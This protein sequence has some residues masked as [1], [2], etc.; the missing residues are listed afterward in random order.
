MKIETMRIIDRLVGTPVCK[1]LG[2]L[3]PVLSQ[4]P[5]GDTVILCKFFGIGSICLSYPL[6]EELKRQNKEVTYLTFKSNEAMV[7]GLGVE[8][9][10][11]ID[12]SSPVRFLGDMV[13]VIRDLRRLGPAVFLNLEFFSRFAAIMSLLSGAPVR[14]GFHMLHLPVGNLYSHRANLNVYR[15]IFENYM[16]VGMAAG[17]VSSFQP[18][19]SYLETFPYHPKSEPLNGISG[20]Y[21]VLNAESSE[22]I[23]A[24]RAWPASAW[25]DLIKRLRN[26]CP[27]H[28]LVMV[29]TDAGAEIYNEIAAHLSEDT[30]IISLV[31]RTSFAE[32]SVVL[33][34][35]SL[36]I[37]VD[38]GP[39]HLS[40]FMKRNTVGLFGPETPVLYGYQL[41]WV[42]NI[43]KNLI[44]SPCL[45]LYDAKK[46]VLDCRD[47]QCMKQISP[48]DVMVEVNDLMSQGAEFQKHFAKR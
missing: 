34:N 29:G 6:I 1:L 2:V 30:N 22:T 46:S 38:S 15:S 47:N 8:Q 35:A 25:V 40:A 3:A 14:A 17:A 23:Q 44:C 48:G 42:R 26:A 13:R 24:L 28:S 37:S 43:H 10:Y 7:R 21:I 20:D 11:T 9:C 31:G 36:V 33:C 45:A 12:P 39:L 27:D 32:F 41:P 5:E 18:L 4:K 16:N 19:E